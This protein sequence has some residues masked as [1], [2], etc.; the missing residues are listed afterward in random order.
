MT[1]QP[2]RDAAT[3]DSAGPFTKAE[4]IPGGVRL[5]FQRVTVDLWH[6]L[7]T[8]RGASPI[9]MAVSHGVPMETIFIMEDGRRLCEDG[10]WDVSHDDPCDLDPSSY[11]HK[12]INVAAPAACD[13]HPELDTPA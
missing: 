10:K 12:I 9:P 8:P 11:V 2:E 3:I 7:V 6:Y 1:E 5:H 13:C 4:P